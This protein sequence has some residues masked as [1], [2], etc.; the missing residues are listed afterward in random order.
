MSSPFPGMDPYLEDPALFGDFR[1]SFVGHLMEALTARLPVPYAAVVLCHFPAHLAAD[2]P[3][4]VPCP[5]YLEVRHRGDAGEQPVTTI[6][7]LDREDKD[8]G[9]GRHRYAGL[10]HAAMARGHLVEVDLLR[11]GTHATQAPIDMLEFFGPDYH[12]NMTRFGSSEGH[13]LYAGHLTA[14]F[15]AVDVPLLPG[16]G[17]VSLELQPA[18]ARTYD[19]G[20]YAGRIDYTAPVPPPELRPLKA[21]WVETMLKEKGLRSS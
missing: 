8:D 3:A 14:S 9:A 12:I 7:V 13:E 18:L 15:P 2:D 20:L 11:G 19:A 1:T 4:A 21:G 16:D 5:S 6:T 10:Q 17:T